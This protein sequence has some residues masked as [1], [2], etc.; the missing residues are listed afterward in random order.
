MEE[1]GSDNVNTLLFFYDCETTGLN[2]YD[3][4]ITELAA[5]FVCEDG[6]S[7]STPIYSSLIRTTRH[8]SA[9]GSYYFKL[10]IITSP[11]Y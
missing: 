3:N 11:S 10:E 6:Q 5:E 2:V 4:H 1:D 9:E 8:I 7:V